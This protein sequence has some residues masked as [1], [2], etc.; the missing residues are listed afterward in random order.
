M[1]MKEL[2]I[3]HNHNHSHNHITSL[4][5]ILVIIITFH[6]FDKA[7]SSYRQ[8][9][10]ARGERGGRRF[11]VG[12]LD[13]FSGCGRRGYPALDSTRYEVYKFF[14]NLI[15]FYYYYYDYLLL[16]FIIYY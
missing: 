15:S 5:I 4:E 14:F 13:Q 2:I 7:T 9:R 3:T 16:I 1:K 6:S 10:T 12:S 8:V 11:V